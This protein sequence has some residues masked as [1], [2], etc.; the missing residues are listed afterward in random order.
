MRLYLVQHGDAVPEDL[1]P[2]RPLTPRGRADVS[3][4]AHF[5]RDAGVRPHRV[6][7]SGKTRA[8]QTAR[9]IDESLRS[10]GGVGAA[11]GLA[12]KDPVEP[13]ARLAASWGTDTLLAG[14]LPFVARLASYLLTGDS[15]EVSVGYKPGSA[16]CM[17]RS[18][19]GG[20]TLVWMLRPELFADVGAAQK[21]ASS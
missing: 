1:D 13:I 19:D 18:E 15:E 5:L 3:A 14:H 11:K 10:P 21:K 16:V 7:H 2:D 12:P 20:W 8:A 6:L 4:L 9:L 17:E